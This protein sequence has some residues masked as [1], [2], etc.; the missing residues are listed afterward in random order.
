MKRNVRLSVLL[1]LLVLGIFM[2]CRSVATTKEVA[3]N[4]ENVS[5]EIVATSDLHGWF[6]PWDFSVDQASTSGSLTYLASMIKDERNNNKNVIYVDCGDSVQ[7]NY[8]EYFIDSD[9]NPMVEALNALDC[10]VWEFGNH[11]Y[12]FNRARRQKLIDGF[13]G[14]VLSGNIYDTTTK[15]RYLPA[16]T[17]IE[18]E[19]VKI[20]FIGMVTP[21]ITEF[22]AGKDSLDG[23]K[24][25]NPLD[26]IGKAIQELQDQGV[27]AIIGVLHMGLDEEN[28]VE[29]SGVADIAQAFPQF[30]AIIAGHAHVLVDKKDINGV[31]VMEPYRYGSALG[32]VNLSFQKKDGKYMLTAK[33][34]TAKKIAK[35]EDPELVSLMEPYKQELSA[36]VNTPIGKLE[37]SDLSKTDAIKGIS[38]VYTESTGIMNLLFAASQYYSGAQAV[39]L[40]TD[41]ENAGF[42][43]GNIS[44][45]N[46]SSSYTYSG[47]EITTYNISGADLKAL[48]E[49]TAAY[50]NKI[51]PGDLTVSYAPDRRESKYSTDNI[52]GG[53]TYSIDLQEEVG[54]RIKNLCLITD[55]NEDG[56]VKLV[57]GSP[58]TRPI[59]AEDSIILGTNS[60]S[61]NKWMGKGGPLEGKKYEPIFSSTTQWGDYGTVR[62]LT[63]R[64]IKEAQKGVLDGNAFNYE[65]WK[66]VTGID[67]TSKAFKKTVEL[68]NAGKLELPKLK[69]GRTNVGAITIEEVNQYL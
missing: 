69:N 23:L 27:D 9:K 40:N 57:N 29:G 38:S 21:L 66:L 19:G 26:E 25:N 67:T 47:G 49:Y 20:G 39:I 58:V 50:F 36:Y 63:I 1:A 31:L 15:N 46:I 33:D 11:E 61:F 51:N 45:K 3:A 10:D 35:T 37:N 32:F 30:D 54:N 7:A 64:Y 5:V 65:N 62:E 41:A 14:T 55:Y 18:R 13:N 17:V 44:I 12:N 34:V 56:T 22:E 52:A 48:L 24:V 6:V 28:N 4:P 43:V 2:S 68:L 16:T 42:P 8:V 53:V 59:F 60:Y